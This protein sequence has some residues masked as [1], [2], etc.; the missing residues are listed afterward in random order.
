MMSY[1]L[2]F[3]MGATV[4]IFTAGLLA[5]SKINNERT[6][7]TTEPYYKCKVNPLDACGDTCCK[8]CLGANDCMWACGGN[9]AECG[10]SFEA[11]QNWD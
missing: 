4:G 8:F 11:E 6:I 5:T 1:A 10:Q 2:V 9:P 7:T 3:I